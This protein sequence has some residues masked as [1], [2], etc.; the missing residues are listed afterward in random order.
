MEGAMNEIPRLKDFDDPSFD[1]VSAA[2]YVFG[3]TV[4]PH[5]PLAMARRQSPI[6]EGSYADLVNKPEYGSFAD[7]GQKQFLVLGY[8]EVAQIAN[9][10]ENFPNG[11]AMEKIM[12]RTFG[13][14]LSL[15]DPPMHGRLRR[16]FQA[17]FLPKT[18]A[19]W[20]DDIVAP[21]VHKLLDKIAAKGHADLV[22]DFTRV[23]PFHVIYRQLNLPEDEAA[24]FHRLSSSQML[25]GAGGRY[26]DR[27]REASAKLGTYFNKMIAVRRQ[28]PGKD[29][30]SVLVQAE[31]D[32]EKLSD[33][34][35]ISFL[36]QLINA[37]GETTFHGTSSLLAALLTHPDQ[38][39]AVRKD[40]EL[41]PQAIEEALRWEPSSAIQLRHAARDMTISGVSIPK[42][43]HI[44]LFF[45]AANRDET[46]FR[47]PERFDIFR[48]KTRH[49]GFGHGPHLC[50]GQHLARIEMKGAL[51]AVLD[52]LPDLRLDPAKPAPVI[53]GTNLRHPREIHVLFG[54]RG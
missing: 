22:S 34:V 42:G 27:A 6:H 7:P 43:S 10:A 18:I 38:L 19:A 53:R 5:T 36:R 44:E 14:S 28:T 17:A 40:R 49:F 41:V 9:D 16:I 24:I 4:D 46:V 2:G 29:L 23:Y 37:A 11:P 47:D 45:G 48:P 50:I 20:G 21:V 54:A 13:N 31:V 32:G 26:A 12:R 3:D 1:P 33:D 35:V 8:K 39:D 51:N 52:R 25:L 15:M 30:V